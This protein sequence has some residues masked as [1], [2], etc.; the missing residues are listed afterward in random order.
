MCTADIVLGH[1]ECTKPVACGCE[2]LRSTKSDSPFLVTVARMW[3]SRNPWPSSSRIDSPLKIPSFPPAGHPR[4]GPPRPSAARVA[5]TAPLL[6]PAAAL[7]A[8]PLGS[9]QDLAHRLQHGREAVL[10][11]QLEQPPLFDS[12]RANHRPNIA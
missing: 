1:A 3:T 9:I 8:L 12:G 2:S 4:A 10:V 11:H 5:L 6:H 7:P